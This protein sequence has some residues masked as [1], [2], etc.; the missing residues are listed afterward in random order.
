MAKRTN[1]KS[2]GLGDTIEKVTKATGI[3]KA[4]ELFSEVTGVD[5]GCDKRKEYLNKKYS[6]KN[7]QCMSKD[8]Y[9]YFKAYLEYYDN[10]EKAKKHFES[11]DVFMLVNMHAR[12]FGIR[13]KVCV[14][15]NSGVTTMNSIVK[16]L[17][18]VYETYKTDNYVS[19]KGE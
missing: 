11:K 1:T 18:T 4:V 12:I 13:P 5:C 6:Y 17:R 3:K 8:D 2:K 19:T 15:C 9:D 16:N 14:N 10:N 7:V